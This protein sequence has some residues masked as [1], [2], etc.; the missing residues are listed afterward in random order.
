ME[1]TAWKKKYNAPFASVDNW[2]KA[3]AE[4]FDFDKTNER[5]TTVFFVIFI[6]SFT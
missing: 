3:F 2:R 5:I 6:E 4:R 1:T